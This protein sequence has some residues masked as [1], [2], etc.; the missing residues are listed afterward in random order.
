[1]GKY[2]LG[3]LLVVVLLVA[4]PVTAFATLPASKAMLV[5]LGYV[6]VLYLALK[7]LSWFLV[8][9]TRKL[10][11]RT[12]QIWEEQSVLMGRATTTIHRFE[13]V[14]EP[15]DIEKPED[16]ER[17]PGRYLL[18]DATISPP[19]RDGQVW[20]PALVMLEREVAS[21]GGGGS[22]AAPSEGDDGGSI[23]EDADEPELL[24]G[25]KVRMRILDV[26]E[27]ELEVPETLST[28]ARLRIVFACPPEMTGIVK[29]RYLSVQLGELTIGGRAELA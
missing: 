14:A 10:A 19:L 24:S 9:A 27:R 3:C 25:Q 17:K 13:E 28:P 11:L 29:L 7:G 16:G 5:T 12:Q 15:A 4:V 6:V 26:E 23:D 21:E 18:L 2:A 20:E 22:V 8:R 1:M